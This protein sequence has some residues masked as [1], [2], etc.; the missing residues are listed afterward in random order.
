ME[1]AA[2][3][4]SKGRVTASP[5]LQHALAYLGKEFSFVP[6]RPESKKPLVAWKN[7][8]RGRPRPDEVRQWFPAGTHNGI[9]IVTGK[10]SG[11]VVLDIDSKEGHRL[12][13]KNGLPLHRLFGQ[14]GAGTIIS[15]IRGKTLQIF[16]GGKICQGWIFEV[17]AVM[18]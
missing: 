3:I 16:R 14:S 13:R 11:I 18:S 12:A 6:L 5:Q 15:S 1:L 9:G 17:M 7:Y 10:I 2:C 4:S 8:Q